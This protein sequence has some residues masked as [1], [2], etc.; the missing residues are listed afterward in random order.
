MK[1]GE[2]MKKWLRIWSFEK[3]EGHLMVII[4]SMLVIDVLLGI[5]ARFVHF[6]IVFAT[7]L[8]KYLF[9]WLCLIGISAAAK[10]NQHIRISYIAERLPFG[11]GI[12]WK[13]SQIIFLIF[14]I[15]MLYVSIRLAWM[16][17]I[18][19]KSAVGF[20]FPM[21]VFTAALPVGFLLTSFRL[22][23]DIFGRHRLSVGGKWGSYEVKRD[24]G[25]KEAPSNT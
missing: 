13:L 22:M 1:A 21:Y 7:E 6:E 17:F 4:T 11:P 2:T 5:V 20:N 25:L 16:Q 8:G 24:K 10:D 9:I 3:L 18:M 15:L 14:S 19:K 23:K 12:M